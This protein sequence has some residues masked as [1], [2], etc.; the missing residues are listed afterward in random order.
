MMMMALV[1]LVST[2]FLSVLVG[3]E[4]V[5]V[6]S[7]ELA[8]KKNE[9]RLK[10]GMSSKSSKK[11]KS[12]KRKKQ[13]KQHRDDDDD[14]DEIDGWFWDVG[15]DCLHEWK[16]RFQ[17][18]VGVN[19]PQDSFDCVRSGTNTDDNRMEM[20]YFSCPGKITGYSTNYKLNCDDN[21]NW[22]AIVRDKCAGGTNLISLDDMGE[23][24]QCE[25]NPL[26]YDDKKWP[27]TAL[28]TEVGTQKPYP[29]LC[30]SGREIRFYFTDYK[31]KKVLS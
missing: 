30:D 15:D 3:A 16:C 25:I 13:P 7:H 29:L 9:R 28:C 18:Q 2:F 20:V 14:D 1:V 21:D 10:G 27:T 12:P 19:H 31:G 26:Y 17:I 8:K 22:K 4:A 23:L 6:E 5:V 24:W 11:S